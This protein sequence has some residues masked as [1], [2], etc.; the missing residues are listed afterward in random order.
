MYFCAIEKQDLPPFIGS[1]ARSIDLV[2]V[3]EKA[4]GKFAY[5]PL[6]D[7]SRLCLDYDVT[8]LPPKA[9]LLPPKETLL[10][11]SRC[12]GGDCKPAWGGQPLA[13]V[14]VHPYDIKAIGQL[15]RIFAEGN[16]D[17]HYR[18]RRENLVIIGTDIT[19]PAKNA[20]CGAMKSALVETGYDL[21]LTD[22]G[23]RY[24]V[25]AGTKKGEEILNSHARRR[26]ATAEEIAK[27][28]ARRAAIPSLY[29]GNAVQTPYEELP[30]L[31]AASEGCNIYEELG[32]KCF[33][34]GSCNLV[35]PTCYCFDVQDELALDL[36]NGER[37]RLWDGC[38]LDGFA[39]VATGENFREDRAERIRHRI[40]R[41]GKYIYEKYGEHGCVGC[42]RCVSACLP[43]IANPVE[44][45]NRLKEGK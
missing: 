11:F 28:D 25:A 17:Q 36:V 19:R 22:I 1:L 33:S 21:L 7:P 2:G 45:F 40:S 9:Y 20:F 18:Q 42:G 16:N 37:V 3:Q 34:C 23:E 15:D 43:D 6:D 4:A 32:K 26:P 31:L 24:V 39:H 10:K 44:I 13:I 41:K 5:A 12:E 38:L 29:E 27:R 35:C 14:G 8:I 30:A